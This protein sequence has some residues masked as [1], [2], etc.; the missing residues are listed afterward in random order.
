[1][2]TQIRLVRKLH[3]RM[4]TVELE[5][6]LGRAEAVAAT[7]LADAR[8]AIGQMRDN[9]VRDTGLLPALQDLARRF[10]QRSGVDLALVSEGPAQDWADE[11]AE[12]AFRIVEE[13]LRNVERHAQ[14][15]AVAVTLRWSACVGAEGAGEVAGEATTSVCIEV[16]DDG[17]GFD[18][19]QLQS[20]HYGLRGMQEQA[21]LIDARL[22]VVSHS[23]QGSRVTL[24]CR[25]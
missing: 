23:G 2:L 5:D 12:T 8:A 19:R 3:R 10:R 24:D 20:G 16:A 15:Q 25:L 21:A 22:D 17:V 4:D 14:A 7:G 11:R 13:A 18:P 1:L 9:G 6:E